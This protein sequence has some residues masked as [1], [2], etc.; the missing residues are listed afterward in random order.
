MMVHDILERHEHGL[1]LYAESIK[2]AEE[3][4]KLFKSEFEDDDGTRILHPARARAILEKYLTLIA[5]RADHKSTVIP[6]DTSRQELEACSV[7]ERWIDGY[8]RAW[9][10]ETKRNPWRR[11]V[12]WHLLRGR[13]CLQAKFDPTYLKTDRLPIRTY[14]DDPLGIYTV[15]GRDGIAWY[16]Q[17]IE[18][19][20]WEIKRDIERHKG[21]DKANRWRSVKLPDDEH[22]T[23]VLVEYWDDDICAALVDEKPLYIKKNPYGFIPL[24]EAHCMD[25]PL[26]D[27]EWAFQSVLAPIADSLKQLYGLVSQLLKGAELM[28]W[29]TLLVQGLDGIIHAYDAGTIKASEIPAATKVDIIQPTINHQMV[30]ALM[31]WLQSDISLGSIPDIAW[32]QEPSNLESGFAI[33]QVLQQVMDKIYDKKDNL[34]LAF[35]WHWGHVLRLVDDFGSVSG[36][37]LKVPAMLEVP[38][39]AR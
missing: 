17:E 9:I 20:V 32:G 8:R 10:M 37:N 12:Y 26:E 14:A 13:M 11:A 27:M 25:T 1:G 29:P 16:T 35:G 18:T 3:I 19:E 23:V 6:R 21:E 38:Y 24:A 7:I 2:Q 34:E 22:D 31:A 28:I 4:E 5:V 36:A 33:G 39:D 30:G 15:W